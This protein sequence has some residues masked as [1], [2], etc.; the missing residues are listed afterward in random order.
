[1]RC[2]LD[3]EIRALRNEIFEIQD[4]K[5]KMTMEYT[6]L[7]L[8]YKMKRK[9]SKYLERKLEE[10]H[11]SCRSYAEWT[12]DQMSNRPEFTTRRWRD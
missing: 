12:K 9:H 11:E 8:Y 7:M 3:E 6:K 5:S 10:G 4:A 2:T 1:M